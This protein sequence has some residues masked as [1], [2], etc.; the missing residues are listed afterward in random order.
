MR[1]L[2]EYP[3][4]REAND[5]FLDLWGK[6]VHQE[7]YDR[8]QWDALQAL[9]EGLARKGLGLP[10]SFNDDKTPV[11]RR[12]A[13]LEGSVDNVTWTEISRSPIHVPISSRELGLHR[14]LWF[15][16]VIKES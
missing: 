16:T 8:R 14:F 10:D 12:V 7:G 4:Y 2:S 15:R 6:A 9:M 13:V 1:D 5:L 3:R 11:E